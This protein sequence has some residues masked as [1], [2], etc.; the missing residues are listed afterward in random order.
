M[1]PNFMDAFLLRIHRSR[2]THRPIADDALGR[3]IRVDIGGR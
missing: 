3:C 1:S 2:R